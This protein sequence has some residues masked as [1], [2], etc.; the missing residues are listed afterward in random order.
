M[1]E[2]HSQAIRVM[3]LRRSPN[4]GLQKTCFR[5]QSKDYEIGGGFVSVR[6]TDKDEAQMMQTDQWSC[7]GYQLCRGLLGPC[8]TSQK[9]D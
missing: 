2:T 4:V 8:T 6:F 9:S 5:F 7:G 1:E 3:G